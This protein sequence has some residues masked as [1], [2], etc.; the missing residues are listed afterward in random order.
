VAKKKLKK[1][2]YRRIITDAEAQKR[3]GKI[4]SFSTLKELDDAFPSP[5]P[6]TVADAWDAMKE[7]NELPANYQGM[8][9][10]PFRKAPVT[11]P[12]TTE[13]SLDGVVIEGKKEAQEKVFY[14]RILN[15]E[16]C[17]HKRNNGSSHISWMG[18][19]NK[20][21]KGV[22]GSC[23]SPFDTRDAKDLLLFLSDPRAARTMGIAGTYN[24]RPDAALWAVDPVSIKGM[25]TYPLTLTWKQRIV[26]AWNRFTRWFID[27]MNSEV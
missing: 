25:P 21:I 4:L 1:R 13:I 14:T 23:F 3:L 26:N 9:E 17:P 8:T 27:L 22:C 7:A 11:E 20:I 24:D 10:N 15:K 19:S 18:H 5:K 12:E 2:K 16:S 6:Q